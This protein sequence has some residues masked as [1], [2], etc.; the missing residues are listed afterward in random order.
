MGTYPEHHSDGQRQRVAIARALAMD[1]RVMLF[2]ELTP[3]L[4][5]E[6]VGEGAARDG[7]GGGEGMTVLVGDA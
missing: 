1:P 7:A 6:L 4:D 2:D 5:P 3:L